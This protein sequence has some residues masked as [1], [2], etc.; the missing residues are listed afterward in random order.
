MARH[1]WATTLHAIGPNQSQ[2]G[3]GREAREVFK[4]QMKKWCVYL[5]I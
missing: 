1:P 2:G 4:Q 5:S 3:L